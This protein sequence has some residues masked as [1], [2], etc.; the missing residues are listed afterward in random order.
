MIDSDGDVI[1]PGFVD[2]HTHIV[3][4]GDRVDEFELKIKGADYL[5]I[6]ANGGGIISTVRQTRA[7]SVDDLVEQSRKRLDKMLACGTTTVEIKTGYGLDT[8]TEIKMLAVI[9]E[10][11]KT[12][13]IDVVPTFLAAHAVPFR[14]IK[15]TWFGWR[16][17]VSW[18]SSPVLLTTSARTLP[19]FSYLWASD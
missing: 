11:D 1:C 4:A 5:E 2:P 14:F 8:E 17:L 7:A 19:Q 16:I 12:H 9:E 10:L 15:N 3:F 18:R 6:L 13:T